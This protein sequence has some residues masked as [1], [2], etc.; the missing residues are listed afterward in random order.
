LFEF[1]LFLIFPAALAFAG[2]MD[3]FTM[4]IPNRVSLGLVA[5][6]VVAAP[7]SSLDAAGV[8]GHVGAGALMLVIGILMFARG[9]LGGGD[10]KLLAAVALW[11]GFDRLM[12]YLVYVSMAGG[13]LAFM[14]LLYRSLAPPLWLCNQDWA[15]R[16]H[17]RTGGIPYGIAL[18]IGGLWIY[19]STLWFTSLAV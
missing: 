15:M 13:L 8:L 10:A 4:T 19:P 12:E 1:A 16:L 17:A 5:G 11:L 7:F 14:I 9:W 18:A 3:L 2:S 6:F